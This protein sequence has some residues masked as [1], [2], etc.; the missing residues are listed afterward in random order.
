MRSF[1]GYGNGTQLHC[2]KEI[3]AIAKRLS[4]E[5]A[6]LLTSAYFSS[7]EEVCFAIPA[8]ELAL[9]RNDWRPAREYLMLCKS[10]VALGLDIA[11]E[12]ELSEK[13]KVAL[14][15]YSA[16]NPKV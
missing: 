13:N 10:T 16:G 7:Q 11:Q 14:F 2:P 5:D 6:A 12:R 15:P 8:M 3:E 1:G 4:P 9:S